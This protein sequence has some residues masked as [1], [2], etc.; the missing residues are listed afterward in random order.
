MKR[1]RYFMLHTCKHLIFLSVLD[2]KIVCNDKICGCKVKRI[3]QYINIH[4]VYV[5][6]IRKKIKMKEVTTFMTR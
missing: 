6:H 3:F 4:K 2:P 1:N 5:L